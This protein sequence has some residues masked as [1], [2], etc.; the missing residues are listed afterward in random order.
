[1]LTALEREL[2]RALKDASGGTGE[3]FPPGDDQP[4]DQAQWDALVV[5]AERY[6][7]QPARPMTVRQKAERDK[8]QQELTT[9]LQG[10]VSWWL[11]LFPEGPDRP[12][13]VPKWQGLLAKAAQNPFT[14]VSVASGKPRKPGGRA[15]P[16]MPRL[17]R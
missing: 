8:L 16:G 1:M 11:E 5:K 10:A 7:K 15:R 14:P 4:G 17:S 12:V 3:L 2:L 6:N 9:A 13:D